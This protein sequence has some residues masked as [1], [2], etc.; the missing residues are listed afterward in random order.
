MIVSETA[1]VLFVHAQG[2]GG[3]SLESLILDNVPDARRDMSLR[4]DKHSTLPTI[5]KARPA[6]S[7]FFVFGFVRN[8]WARM[9]SWHLMVKRRA[10]HQPRQV[11]RVS[12]EVHPAMRDRVADLFAVDIDKFGYTFQ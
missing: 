9:L 1:R 5:L 7:E 3:T 6:Q 11:A 8:P 2:T 4:G 12:G 10:R